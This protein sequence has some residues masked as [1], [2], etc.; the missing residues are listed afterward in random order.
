MKKATARK[1][2]EN[3]RENEFACKH[4]GEIP[5]EGISIRL[6]TGLQSLRDELEHPITIISG[7]RCSI[8]NHNV[9]G[10]STSKH[11]DGI[12]ADIVTGG[13]FPILDVFKKAT[14]YF[15][16]VGLYKST[17]NPKTG[18]LHVDVYDDKGPLYW[19]RDRYAERRDPAY[20]SRWQLYNYFTFDWS[21]AERRFVDVMI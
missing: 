19:W 3:F 18:S 8:H 9:G 4:C 7:F 13:K 16:R 2:T 15:P 17:Y 6:V 5:D 20:S 21:E 12:A 1:L 11:L 14:V 10:S